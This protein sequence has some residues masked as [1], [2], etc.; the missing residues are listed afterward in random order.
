MKF[1]YEWEYHS[2]AYMVRST[3][4]R[5]EIYIA[6][7]LMCSIAPIPVPQHLESWSARFR[8]K[9]PQKKWL[10]TF[11]ITAYYHF[12]VVS[13]DLSFSNLAKFTSETNQSENT[14]RAFN[15][16]K[17]I[18]KHSTVSIEYVKYRVQC[19]HFNS[20]GQLLHSTWASGCNMCKKS[21]CSSM[22]ALQGNVSRHLLLI[23]RI[24]AEILLQLLA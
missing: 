4:Y 9:I 20:M 6:L 11:V 14:E 10:Y 3:T 22:Q 1:I 15:E 12:H 8:A 2:L 23:K 19:Q 5:N 7:I 24:R 16:C 13:R 17:F 18:V 21:Q